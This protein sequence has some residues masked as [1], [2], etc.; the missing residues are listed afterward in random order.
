MNDFLVG[1]HSVQIAVHCALNDFG[2]LLR[3]DDICSAVNRDLFGNQFFQEFDCK[4]LL[5]HVCHFFK[6]LRIEQRKLSLDIREKVDN[7]FAFDTVLQKFVNALIYF[8][9]R[10]LLSGTA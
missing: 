3:L 4:I 1:Q 8:R 10:K 5:L 7:A 9:K 6:E 2:E